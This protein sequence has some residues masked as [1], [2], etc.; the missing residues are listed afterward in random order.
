MV[1]IDY[2]AV[3]RKVKKC[4]LQKNITQEELAEI[5]IISPSYIG[6]IERGRRNLSLNTAIQISRS[7]EVG[8]DYLFLDSAESEITNSI[9]S[10]LNNCTKEQKNTLVEIVKILAD[11][12]VK[13]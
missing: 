5:C 3:G 13:L 2:K 8:L 9:N 7:L 1:E 11:N 4:R 12:I 10:A 6:H